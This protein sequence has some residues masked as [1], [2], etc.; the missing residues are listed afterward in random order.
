MFGPLFWVFQNSQFYNSIIR[1]SKRT[2][3]YN[4][5]DYKDH[6]DE[7]IKYKILTNKLL[8][9]LN[10][11]HLSILQPHVAFKD[12]LHENEKKFTR[13]KYREKIVKELY[14][15]LDTKMLNIQNVNGFV[16]LDTRQIFDN[17]NSWIFS[18][19][20]HF[21][22]NNGYKILIEKIVENIN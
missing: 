22:D 7:Y 19:D 15:Y 11:K 3:K 1:L 6:I 5:D 9:N 16:Y 8:Q 21:I 17:N 20:V 12:S 14:N 4:F 2:K 18:D 10:I 13:Y